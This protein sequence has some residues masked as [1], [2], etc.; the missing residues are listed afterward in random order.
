[1]PRMLV[2]DNYLWVSHKNRDGHLFLWIVITQYLYPFPSG[3]S[4]PPKYAFGGDHV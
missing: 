3:V 2:D 4:I 1:M